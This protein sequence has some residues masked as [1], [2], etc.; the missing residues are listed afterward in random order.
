MILT[1]ANKKSIYGGNLILVN[2][3]YP[4]TAQKKELLLPV[5]DKADEVLLAREAA[6]LLD[7]LMEEVDGWAQIAA[8][9]G[10]R[11]K[12]EQEELYTASLLENGEAF[13]KKFVALP[14]HSEHETGLAIDLALKKDEIDFITPAFPYEGICQRFR[15]RAADF[16]F[17]ERYPKGKEEITGIGHEPWHFRYVGVPHAAII[18]ANQLTL[19]EY[20]TMVK[21]YPLGEKALAWAT[22]GVVFQVAYLRADENGNAECMP[23]FEHRHSISGDNQGGF[24]ITQWR[25]AHG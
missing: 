17:V 21:A 11:S 20:H 4:Y 5:S 1:G 14:G 2:R 3:E 6:A 10:W 13:T 12:Q 25:P 18:E 19:E 24:I 16:G 9:S 8:V 7:A 15:N 23:D 22:R